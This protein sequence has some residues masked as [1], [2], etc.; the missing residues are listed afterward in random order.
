LEATSAHR[1]PVGI[2][3]GW[4]YRV[5]RRNVDR[6]GGLINR[7]DGLFGVPHQNRLNLIE[8]KR[9]ELRITPGFFSFW[10]DEKVP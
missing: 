3:N 10:V 2:E 6:L 8:I 7:A 9:E 1:A 5:E 4:R